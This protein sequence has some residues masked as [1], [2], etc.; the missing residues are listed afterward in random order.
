M[1]MLTN[2]DVLVAAF[3]M[4]TNIRPWAIVNMLTTL[5]LLCD[6]PYQLL[7]TIDPPP[8]IYGGHTCMA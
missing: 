1:N 2:F 7:T 6:I 8:H 3:N 4:L 5:G